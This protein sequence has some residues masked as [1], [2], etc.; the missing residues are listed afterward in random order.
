MVVVDTSYAL[1]MLLPDETRQG[2][3]EPEALVEP[4]LCE[5]RAEPRLLGGDP[6]IGRE[7]EAETTSDRRTLD[8]GDD[9]LARAEQA[10]RCGVQLI[11]RGG[12]RTGE[13][14][15]GAE[16]PAGGAQ[17]HAPE[18]VVLVEL[19][20]RRRDTIDHLVREEVVRRVR[21]LDDRHVLATVAD[22]H[23]RACVLHVTSPGSARAYPP[24]PSSTPG[25]PAYEGL[26]TG[27]P[28]GSAI[29]R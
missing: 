13:V 17:H 25:S 14:G 7:R 9:R 18:R 20:E 19:L 10:H 16:V 5:V 12:R 15:T 3:R 29:G 11:G 23:V 28:A 26:S 21:Q 8:H 4:E 22:A 1:A 24:M 27:H 2:H 6:E